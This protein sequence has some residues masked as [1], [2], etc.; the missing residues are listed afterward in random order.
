MRYLTALL[1][2][3]CVTS[4]AFATPLKPGQFA[5]SVNV[6]AE[7]P[8][9]GDVHG[10]ATATV[11]SLAALNPNLPATSAQLRIESRS[12]DDI[13]GNATTYGIEGRF[14]LEGD[15]E[16]FAELRRTEADGGS[17]QVGT[18]FVPALSA[19]LPVNGTFDDFKSTTVEAGVRQYFGSGKVR[20]YVA[21][22]AGVAFT[23]E[24]R[25][26]FRVPV[27]NGVGTEP[28]DI[29]LNNVPF[30]DDSTTV[31]AGLDVGASWQVAERLSVSAEV[32]IRYRGDLDGN[33]AAIGGL[34][35][36]SIN[37]DSD[38]ISVPV[39]VKL[40]YAF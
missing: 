13:Y 8:L 32:G 5:G 34:G 15:R 2:A 23:D 40:S 1:A 33:D 16:V 10:G 30:Y 26:S 21:A 6:G 39:S 35:L 29:N 38:A 17:V 4:P 22:R 7:L 28:N 9:D 11:A 3:A 27:P 25:A 24:I 20:P 31:S 12:Y 18:A 14:G 19:T 36:A 37:N